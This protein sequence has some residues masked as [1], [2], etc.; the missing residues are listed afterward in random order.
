MADVGAFYAAQTISGGAA[1]PDLVKLGES[2]FR[3]GVAR[4]GV[5]SCSGC[6]GPAGR[7]NA[8]ASF[9]AL[10][11]QHAAYLE[12]QLMAFRQGA[13]QPGVDGSRSNDGDAAIMR[14]IAE[15]MSDLEIKAV[16]SFLSGLR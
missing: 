5:A 3:A 8:G 7:G 14:D 13:D 2:V 9:P 12:K 10:A 1:D 16:A 11:G 15:K 4:K 6:H